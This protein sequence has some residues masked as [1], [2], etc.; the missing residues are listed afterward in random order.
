MKPWFTLVTPGP[1]LS[2]FTGETPL[3]RE[4][5]HPSFSWVVSPI[6]WFTFQPLLTLYTVEFIG[7]QA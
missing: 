3:S 5:H 4:P 7:D 2:I 6:S 1:S